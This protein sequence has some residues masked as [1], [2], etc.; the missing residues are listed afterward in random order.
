MTVSLLEILAAARSHAAPLAAESAGYLLLAVADHLVAAP[1][2]VDAD[3]VELMA[4][5]SVRLRSRPA[6]DPALAERIVRRLLG[7]TLEVSSSVGPGL[8]RAAERRDDTGLP[9]LVRELEVALI[10]VN[11]GAAKRALSRLHRETERARD[12]GKLAALLETESAVR[13]PQAAAVTAEA[14]VAPAPVV[15]EVSVASPVTTLPAVVAVSPASRAAAPSR[16]A[17]ATEL[18]LTPPPR[19]S[20]VA[21]AV[22]KPEP[23][24]L[25][26]KER[27]ASTPR[28][29]TL[30]T[31]QTL[32]GEEAERTERAPTVTAI[33]EPELAAS[34]DLDLDLDFNA[35][36]D[37]EPSDDELTPVRLTSVAAIEPQPLSD[38]EPSQ[39]P[40]VLTAMLELHT[41][42]EADDAPTR[43]REVVTELLAVVQ[44]VPL[45]TPEPQQVEDAWLTRSS[46]DD[47]ATWEEAELVDPA[48]HEAATWNP[49]PVAPLAVATPVPVEVATPA[50]LAVASPVTAA[51]DVEV[52][53]AEPELMV[54][55]FESEQADPAEHEALTWYPAPVASGA[56]PLPTSLLVAE[57]APEPSPYAPAALP[58]R[59]HEVSELVDT[60]YVSGGSE[61]TLLRSALKEM[62]GMEPTPMPRPFLE[63]R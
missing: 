26:A 40:D 8:R 30:V 11:R 63:E 54:Y 29:G 19:S 4:D 51:P 55:R 24:V 18:T 21:P 60:F 46:I 28:L 56:T 61:E 45:L 58:T 31:A 52:V 3:D 1:R 37:A 44:P 22:T 62:A 53:P 48:L 25:R 59:S 41:G 2:V 13:L 39:L 50:P 15:A 47:V 14:V 49:A 33:D 35:A 5:G 23:V 43:L 10:P 7:R 38:P 34:P 9:E 6:R 20:E 12:A 16:P 42:L 27:G 17:P 36:A 32:P 57:P